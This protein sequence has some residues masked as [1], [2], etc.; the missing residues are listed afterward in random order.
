MSKSLLLLF[1]LI[2]TLGVQAQDGYR[3]SGK[4]DGVADGELL[5]VSDENGRS[6]QMA[7]TL[8]DILQEQKESGCSGGRLYHDPGSE[9]G[10]SFYIG[11]H[12]RHVERGR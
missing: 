9:G 10:D 11:K 4:I 12:G 8:L 3:I 6:E 1:L 2:A 5:L 7:T